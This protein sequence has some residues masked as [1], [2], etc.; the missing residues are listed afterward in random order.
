MANLYLQ[1][2]GA[3]VGAAVGISYNTTVGSVGSFAFRLET[4]MNEDLSTWK[5]RRDQDVYIYES[6]SDTLMFIGVIQYITPGD[7]L[8]IQGAGYLAHF[9]KTDVT[10]ENSK[11]LIDS[12]RV[13]TTPTTEDATTTEDFADA[14]ADWTFASYHASSSAALSGGA[15]LLHAHNSNNAVGG[16]YARLTSPTFTDTDKMDGTYFQF[17]MKSE[18]LTAGSASDFWQS[19][20]FYEGA[21]AKLTLR[22]YNDAGQLKLQYLSTAPITF[23]DI[24]NINTATYYTVKVVCNPNVDHFSI[25][26]D[27]VLKNENIDKAFTYIS[28]VYFSADVNGS[29]TDNNELYIDDF[30]SS[31][32]R[33]QTYID[34]QHEDTSEYSTA[35]PGLT[36][37]TTAELTDAPRY[38]I[39]SDN[40]DGSTK[41][42]VPTTSAA[43]YAPVNFDVA[44]GG[45]TIANCAVHDL[46]YWS[47][48][49][50]S[51]HTTGTVYLPFTIEDLGV[52]IPDTC[53]LTRI[54]GTIVGQCGTTGGTAIVNYYWS[55]DGTTKTLLLG[56]INCQDVINPEFEK[57]ILINVSDPTTYLGSAGG[58]LTGGGIIIDVAENTHAPHTA[59]LKI[60]S[61]NVTLEYRTATFDPVSAKIST[62]THNASPT[63]YD[64]IKCYDSTP[65]ADSF[66]FGGRGIAEGDT[67][68]FCYGG[69]YAFGVCFSGLNVPTLSQVTI[70]NNVAI[71]KAC[72]VDLTNP[73]NWELWSA[74]CQYFNFIWFATVLNGG[75]N[76]N[77]IKESD[78]AAATITYSTT[79]DPP[80]KAT[81]QFYD[82]IW[83]GA[84]V[85]YKNGVT[86]PQYAASPPAGV[87]AIFREEREDILTETVAIERAVELAEYYSTEQISIGLE[88]N[89]YPTNFPILG[90]KY[91]FTGIKWNGSAVVTD[92]YTDQICRRIAV[93]Q[94]ASWGGEWKIQAWFGRASSPSEEEQ[95]ELLAESLN[96]GYK[97]KMA[98]FNARNIGV[99]SHYQLNGV[100]GTGAVHGS[101]AEM[102]ALTAGVTGWANK[103]QTTRGTIDLKQ[104]EEYSTNNKEL[105]GLAN[106]ADNDTDVASWEGLI[107]SDMKTGGKLSIWIILLETQ[108]IAKTV[109]FT[110]V[111]C[112]RYPKNALYA[113]INAWNDEAAD[114]ITL[115]TTLGSN[116]TEHFEVLADSTVFAA[117][118]H[119]FFKLKRNGGG[120]DWG[121]IAY[122]RVYMTYEEVLD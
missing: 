50:T 41:D 43:P 60:D 96:R 94:D 20:I 103:A 27:T 100:Q 69:D 107:P 18:N 52:P 56:S 121:A 7:S 70:N 81:L 113:D 14:N 21:T 91:S 13:A 102:A 9:K 45:T 48:V 3:T 17:K 23:S 105:S 10:P 58:V 55:K 12:G 84:K 22:I 109:K 63:L 98:L 53:T 40:S 34:V 35:N 87:T 67:W 65:T 86:A 122:I 66:A 4:Y 31:I 92:S 77:A 71:N 90:T 39:I 11:F 115:T 24:Q 99:S 47:L 119:V 26:V 104:C 106:F 118:D 97:N 28:S 44:A 120:D 73:R 78:I 88:W 112:R 8:M 117:Y 49:L 37:T 36:T 85:V 111:F 79:V 72:T 82:N 57:P 89:Y 54:T 33:Y 68:E 32:K 46:V 93:S 25:Y 61:C 51:D 15:A 76:L 1:Y 29:V 114:T 38:L 16:A 116:K 6:G 110:N 19:I 2:G 30:V 108:A 62:I 80:S 42:I 75:Y 64:T 5:A 74:L 59:V 83:G 95:G 101:A